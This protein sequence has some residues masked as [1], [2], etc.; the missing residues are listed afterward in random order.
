[1]IA[2]QIALA[3]GGGVHGV[4]IS[5]SHRRPGTLI[6]VRVNEEFMLEEL[7]VFLSVWRSATPDLQVMEVWLSRV[8]DRW[9]DAEGSQ[10]RMMYEKAGVLC[11]VHW[12]VEPSSSPQW[13]RQ[14]PRRPKPSFQALN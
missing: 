3:C 6:H 5:G 9:K 12:R 4:N 1:M 8:F 2:G 10:L 13:V 11:I 7:E 14:R